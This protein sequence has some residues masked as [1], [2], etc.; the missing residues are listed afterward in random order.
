MGAKWKILDNTI[1]WMAYCISQ[2]QETSAIQKIEATSLALN[3]RH[4]D[5]FVNDLYNIIS[6][7]AEVWLD[8]ASEMTNSPWQ[9]LSD[10]ILMAAK[11]RQLVTT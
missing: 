7:E 8:D 3:Q 11:S 1:A 5:K 2:G 10:L 6:W 9:N 4:G